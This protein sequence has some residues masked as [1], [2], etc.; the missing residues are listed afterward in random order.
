MNY[1]LV[2]SVCFEF[3]DCESVAVFCGLT[4]Y[5]NKDSRDHIVLN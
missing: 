2:S 5:F 4:K 1:N 3:I